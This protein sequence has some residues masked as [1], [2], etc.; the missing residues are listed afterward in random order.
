MIEMN[1]TIIYNL[2]ENTILSM[3]NTHCE[4][5]DFHYTEKVNLERETTKETL[6]EYTYLSTTG[7]VIVQV[8]KLR[9][10]FI[11]TNDKLEETRRYVLESEELNDC[12]YM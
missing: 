11:Q 12:M 5:E 6:I 10:L 4:L 2:V 9:I 1:E 3:I 7:Y 8:E